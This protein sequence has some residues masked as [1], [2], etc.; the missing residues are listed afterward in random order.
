KLMASHGDQI[1]AAKWTSHKVM[2]FL[3][4]LNITGIDRLGIL[5]DITLIISKEL[6]V[7]IRSMNLDSHDGIFEANFD[8]YVHDTEDINNLILNLTKIKGID[9]VKRMEKIEDS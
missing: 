7:N 3:A 8:L 4:R 9:N 6:N 5:N 2:A 1:V